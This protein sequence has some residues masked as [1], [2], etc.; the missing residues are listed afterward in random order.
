MFGKLRSHLGSSLSHLR[1]H[2]ASR[3]KIPR[4][5]P[6]GILLG[7]PPGIPPGIPGG[8][9]TNILDGLSRFPSCN[10]LNDTVES[11]WLFT[12]RS[13]IFIYIYLILAGISIGN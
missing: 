11:K 12:Y 5:I 7:I 2:L 3:S 1:S 6:S 8:I 4:G 9:P 13:Y 10:D